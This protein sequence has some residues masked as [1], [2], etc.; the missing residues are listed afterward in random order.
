LR[1]ETAA[2]EL[3]GRFSR[4]L[5]RGNKSLLDQGQKNSAVG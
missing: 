3:S 1:E 4:G 2:T 5:R